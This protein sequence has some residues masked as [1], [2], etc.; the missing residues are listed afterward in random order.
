MRKFKRY[1]ASVD[2]ELNVIKGDKAILAYLGFNEILNLRQVI[3][4]HDI[5]QLQECISDT[6]PGSSSL[7][8]FRVNKSDNSQEWIAAIIN[9]PQNPEGPIEIELSEIQSLKNVS[10]D[11]Y[12]DKMTGLLNKNAITEYA[13]DLMQS[14]DHKPFYFFL[15]DVDN[16]KAINDTF[17]HMKGD[18]IIT[19]VAHIAKE[20][21]GDNGVVG[22]IGGD[23][24]MLV[25]EN[26]NTEQD[27]RMILL[28]IRKTVEDKYHDMGENIC[29]TV[30]MGGALFPTDAMDYDSM[31]M[32]ADKMLYIA[33]T[34]GR[35]RYIIYTPLIHGKINYDGKV[36]TISQNMMMNREKSALMMELMDDFLIKKTLS[37]DEAFEKIIRGYSLDEIYIADIDGQKSYFGLQLDRHDDGNVI[38]THDNIELPIIGSGELDDMFSSSPTT[39]IGFDLDK[40]QKPQI[41]EFMKMNDIRVVVAYKMSSAS[42]PGYIFYMNHTQSSC[43]FS[44]TDLA[45]LTYFSHMVELSGQYN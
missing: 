45:D 22:R 39:V 21:I 7:T 32:L 19:D 11:S 2:L 13:S 41:A 31:F 3:P 44:L 36:M 34:K 12:Y 15:M 6:E 17:G 40:E 38:C 5:I 23:E 26:I 35:N 27:L 42:K 20:V 30:S 14:K 18:E 10:A 9:K 1:V 8:C 43:R 24:F 28:T 16:F 37:T 33:K 29:T 25:L 4:S